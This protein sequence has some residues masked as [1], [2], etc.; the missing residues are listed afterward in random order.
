[1]YLVG[2]LFISIN[3]SIPVI[4]IFRIFLNRLI[5]FLLINKMKFL[6]NVE[7]L[8][9]IFT[10]CVTGVSVMNSPGETAEHRH[11]CMH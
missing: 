4:V 1:M 10:R 8:F 9:D 11:H 5:P 7:F 6:E 2:L 3:T